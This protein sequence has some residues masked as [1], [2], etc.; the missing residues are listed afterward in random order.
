MEEEG[1]W[2]QAE[3]TFYKTKFVQ[4][5][6]KIIINYHLNLNQSFKL[7][8]FVVSLCVTRLKEK[9]DENVKLKSKYM[10]HF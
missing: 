1:R 6:I 8:K 10:F 9:D 3:V 7:M 5:K 4:N 2:L